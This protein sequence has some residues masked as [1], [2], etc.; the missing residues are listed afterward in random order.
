MDALKNES[1]ILLMNLVIS[2]LKYI[3]KCFF[4]ESDSFNMSNLTTFTR[5]VKHLPSFKEG[6][7]LVNDA[8]SSMSHLKSGFVL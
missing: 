5:E 3:I 6:S 2:G 4:Y 1:T 8:F 7:I